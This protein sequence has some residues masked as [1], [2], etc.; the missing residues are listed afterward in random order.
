M[1]V[2]MEYLS[3]CQHRCGFTA[4]GKDCNDV[5]YLH[6]NNALACKSTLGNVALP[7]PRLQNESSL[8][9]VRQVYR[10]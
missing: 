10:Y 8:G 3:S 6:L 5:C 1:L 2:M 7:F 9:A 4:T